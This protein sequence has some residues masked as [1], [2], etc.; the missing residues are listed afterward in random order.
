LVSTVAEILRT[1][2][3][4]ETML[5]LALRLRPENARRTSP[6]LLMPFLRTAPRE[7][8]LKRLNGMLVLL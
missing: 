3:V 5:V 7:N 8:D 6:D 4:N 2:L 1:F